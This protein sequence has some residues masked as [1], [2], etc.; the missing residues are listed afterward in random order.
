MS[1]DFDDEI[2]LDAF[3][4]FCDEH[5]FHM[6]PEDEIIE[7]LEMYPDLNQVEAEHLM[8]KWERQGTPFEV[9]VFE[10]DALFLKY[11]FSPRP[12]DTRRTKS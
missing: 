12:A 3:G 11:G 2:D 5:P 10:A 7:A 9:K 8:G 6:C 4:R 1:D